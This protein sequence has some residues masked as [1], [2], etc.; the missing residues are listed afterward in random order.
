[1]LPR[2]MVEMNFLEVLGGRARAL[3]LWHLIYFQ[4]LGNNAPRYLL[5]S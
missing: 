3:A 2:P 5:I 1:M 4:Y